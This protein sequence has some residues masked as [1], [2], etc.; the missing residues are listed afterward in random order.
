MSN[1][2]ML[3]EIATSIYT[4][5]TLRIPLATPGVGHIFLCTGVYD[6]V[7]PSYQSATKKERSMSNL[8]ILQVAATSVCQWLPSVTIWQQHRYAII[9]MLMPLNIKSWY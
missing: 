4:V 7:S 9:K 2:N 6:F 1:L 8:I 3:Q 5:V